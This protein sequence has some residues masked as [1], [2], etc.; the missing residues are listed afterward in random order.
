MEINTL[1]ELLF[2]KKY[3]IDTVNN[4]VFGSGS[5]NKTE[6]AIIGTTNEAYIGI[7][8]AYSFVDILIDIIEHKPKIPI[9]L[10]VDTLGQKLSHYD[11]LL[12]LNVYL[13][14]LAKTIELARLHGHKI[15]SVVR[16]QAVS[17]G[18]LST[19]M[20]ADSCFAIKGSNI[21][22]MN[23]PSMARITRIPLQKLE[24]LSESSPLFDTNVE[25]YYQMGAINAI[26]DSEKDMSTL[27][28]AALD[29][30][31]SDD[32]KD[33]GFKRKGRMKTKHIVSSINVAL[34]EK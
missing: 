19:N 32:R 5:I 16:N 9:L 25:N 3:S 26:W 18:I 20:L 27:L 15:I 7:E 13:G 29:E 21:G 31:N 17:G 1:L 22:V 14:H 12:G 34:T 2:K 4:V 6:I 23:L 24:K 28:L 10:L 11:E 30:T 33:K 8:M